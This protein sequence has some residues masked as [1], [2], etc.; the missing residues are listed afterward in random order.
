M[1]TIDP[2]TDTVYNK[3]LMMTGQV[4]SVPLVEW[5]YDSQVIEF[6]EQVGVAHGLSQDGW[7]LSLVR[8]QERYQF[9]EGQREAEWYK[10]DPL[11]NCADGSK[12]DFQWKPLNAKQCIYL[13][14]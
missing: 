13:A 7:R 11:E 2:S 6:V 10:K 5:T 9:H 12:C 3:A 8:S 14:L 1:N 4:A